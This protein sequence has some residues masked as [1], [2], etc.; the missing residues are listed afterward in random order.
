[1]DRIRNQSSAVNSLF[2]ALKGSEK[3]VYVPGEEWA[4]WRVWIQKIGG[5]SVVR[6]FRQMILQALE[7]TGLRR[8]RCENW[9]A[10]ERSLGMRKLCSVQLSS[11][12]TPR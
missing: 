7:R 5:K 8:V 1:M 2:P 6:D 9:D 11:A 4:V 12:A 10:S 3:V